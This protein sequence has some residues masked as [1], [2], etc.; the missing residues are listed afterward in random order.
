MFFKLPSF[1]W[2]IFH[3]DQNL[4]HIDQKTANLVKILTESK[5]HPHAAHEVVSAFTDGDLFCQK[6][7]K[8]KLLGA[9]RYAWLL[10]LHKLTTQ[11]GIPYRPSEL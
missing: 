7:T 1:L 3:F 4:F 11:R 10:A 9:V 5:Q 6:M 8:L 2:K